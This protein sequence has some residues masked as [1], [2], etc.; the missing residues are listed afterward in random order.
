M[1][2]QL[3]KY[4][5]KGEIVLYHED[6]SVRLEVML[7]N[8]TVWLTQQQMAELFKTTKQNISL[9]INNSF[10]EG[11]LIPE[12]V[13][14]ES[15][16][17]ADDGKNYRTKYYNLDVIISVGYRVKSKVVTFCVAG[18]SKY[19]RRSSKFGR[20]ATLECTEG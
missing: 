15:L 13:L 8:E 18:G 4:E 12:S 2:N 14:K 7:Q 20:P 17:T 16:T 11:E 9:H 5:E 1:D 19:R 6:D 10:R 3:V